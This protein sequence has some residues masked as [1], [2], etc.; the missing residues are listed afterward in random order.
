MKNASM[1]LLSLILAS[2]FTLTA[3]VGADDVATT[4]AE[5]GKKSATYVSKRT[6]GRKEERVTSAVVTL[7]LDGHFSTPRLN[8]A[9]S[10]DLFDEYFEALDPN[11]IYFLAQDIEEFSPYREILDDMLRR[12]SLDFPFSVYDRYLQRVEERVDYA[13]ERL[14]K[15]FDFSTD[16]SFVLDR[17][18]EAWATSKELLDEIWRKRIKNQLLLRKLMRTAPENKTETD[19]EREAR[20]K[21]LAKRKPED[22]VLRGYVNYF[23]LLNNNDTYDVMENFLTVFTSIFDPHSTYMNWRTLEDFDI[24]MS[25]S[26][27]GIGA[28]L[29]SSDGYTQVVR[30]I[31][32]GPAFQDGR[33]KPG[34]RIIAVAQGE[35]EPVDVLN[36]PLHKVVRMIRGKKGAV[37]RLTVIHSLQGVPEEIDITRDDVK[38]EDSAAHGDV[39][40]VKD[41]HGTERKVG[42]I[43]LPSFYADWEAMKRNDPD[44]KSATGDVRRLIDKMT[45]EDQIE[46]LI[47]DLRGNGG[48]SLEESISLAGMFIPRGIMVQVKVG[49]GRVR[50]HNDDDDG[51]AYDMPLAVMVDRTSASA[52]EIFAGAIQDYGRGIL[53]GSSST[54]GKGTVQTVLRLNKYD[55]L[56]DMKPGALKYT[57]AKF[58]RVTG[59]S[60]QKKGVVP[61]IVF[62]SFYDHMDIGESNLEHVLPW[63]EIPAQKAMPFKYNVNKYLPRL[64]ANSAKRV[65]ESEEIQAHLEDIKRYGIRRQK[66][67]FTLNEEKRRELRKEDEYWSEKINAILYRDRPGQPKDENQ[68]KEE[69][70]AKEDE[71]PKP[72]DLYLEETTHILGDLIKLQQTDAAKD[73]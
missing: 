27:Q 53:I 30:I 22:V 57:M 68:E 5:S 18:T 46:G 40:T 4:A 23:Q 67:E 49:P 50:Q 48:G 24:D 55:A 12:G 44:P 39:L 63:D 31:P 72:R 64:K 28:V 25:L 11:K 13:R 3:F 1:S 9:R 10:R 73:E 21:W 16:E 65:A 19:E 8:D 14:K 52:S 69:N 62:P 20:E 41:E 61:D 43:Y 51:F 29:T 2:L 17:D 70:E 35:E 6:P 7:F 59:H 32:G 56:K 26:L 33:L 15:P 42:Y 36:M 38:L 34:D 60:T 58:Y 37:V 47:M 66:K 71:K 45:R 54:H